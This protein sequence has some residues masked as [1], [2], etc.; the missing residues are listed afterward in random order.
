MCSHTLARKVK[1]KRGFPKWKLKNNNKTATSSSIELHEFILNLEKVITL[2][3]KE[4]N[5]QQQYIKVSHKS[6]VVQPVLC[7]VH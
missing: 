5:K 1:R 4:E 3:Q 2:K 7:V 6:I